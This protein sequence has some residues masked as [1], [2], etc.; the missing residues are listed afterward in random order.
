VKFGSVTARSILGR[1]FDWHIDFF[2]GRVVLGWVGCKA[3]PNVPSIVA[4][5]NESD[6]LGVQIAD[7]P[8]PDVSALGFGLTGFSCDFEQHIEGPIVFAVTNPYVQRSW[9][10]LNSRLRAPVGFGAID[11]IRLDRI[12]GWAIACNAGSDVEVSLWQG[13]RR[14]CATLAEIERTDVAV[15]FHLERT[16]IGFDLPVELGTSAF[17]EGCFTL[18]G[19]VEGR[20]FTIKDGL[21]FIESEPI[22]ERTLRFDPSSSIWT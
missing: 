18:K 6:L 13:S 12:A 3:A 20:S 4:F 9:T 16:R 15:A 21:T 10:T 5:R 2:N 17:S 22:F 11:V 8:R 7:L 1:K 19:A 14:V